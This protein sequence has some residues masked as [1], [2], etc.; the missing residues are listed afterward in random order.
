MLTDLCWSFSSYLL[1]DH[2]GFAYI[3]VSKQKISEA[4]TVFQGGNIVF[5]DSYSSGE[6]FQRGWICSLCVTGWHFPYCRW[7]A[8]IHAMCH[9]MEHC[10]E[11]VGWPWSRFVQLA[12]SWESRGWAAALPKAALWRAMCIDPHKQICPVQSGFVR[13]FSCSQAAHSTQY[14]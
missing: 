14:C 4:I 9:E 10:S 13:A 7:E 3:L 2:I 6:F 12:E 8:E 11:S 1:K 5:P